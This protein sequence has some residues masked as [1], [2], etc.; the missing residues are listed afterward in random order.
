MP[1]LASPPVLDATGN[2]REDALAD[3]ARH[4]VTT[5]GTVDA[6]RVEAVKAAGVSA[7][8]VVDLTLASTLRRMVSSSHHQ[9]RLFRRPTDRPA[10]D[11]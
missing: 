7:A 11:L 4:L 8:Q 2:A 3:F 5:R 6:G 1:R 9:H 10:I